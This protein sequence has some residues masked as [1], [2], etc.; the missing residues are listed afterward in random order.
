MFV[1]LYTFVQKCVYFVLSAA[2]VTGS[3][4][5]KRLLL[6]VSGQMKLVRKAP[7]PFSFCPVNDI[8]FQ[9]KT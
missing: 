9:I 6:H 2:G 4:V 8:L 1:R 3:G 7:E 5:N